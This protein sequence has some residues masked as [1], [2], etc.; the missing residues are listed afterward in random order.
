MLLEDLMVFDE[1]KKDLEKK[2]IRHYF[3]T[4]ST[5]DSKIKTHN[6]MRTFRGGKHTES[7][8][9]ALAVRNG[10]DPKKDITKFCQVK[11]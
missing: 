3:S 10:L 11:V 2:M 7:K 8:R 5:N 1:I 4:W 9:Q 6:T